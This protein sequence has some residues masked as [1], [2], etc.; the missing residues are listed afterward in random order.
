LSVKIL[1]QFSLIFAILI[2]SPVSFVLS[3]EKRIVINE[4]AWMGT[5]EQWQNE[6]IE[7]YN[8]TNSLIS[9]D[10]WIL[11]AKDD[12]PKI[13]LSGKIGAYSYFLLERTDDTTVPE[14]PADQVYKGGLNNQGE[15]L[16]LLNNFG[17]MVDE[18]DC[19]LG[20]FS[21]SNETKKTMERIHPLI[22]GCD[23]SNWKTS[24]KAG[25]TPGEENSPE[26]KIKKERDVETVSAASD[27]S[28]FSF[29]LTIGI[30]VSLFISMLV[31]AFWLKIKQKKDKIKTH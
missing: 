1:I 14:I 31:L 10:K 11:K 7:L 15:H 26:T 8:P 24:Q 4:I 23:P 17:E 12:S 9:L 18:T 29:L 3:Q 2:I 27:N 13:E 20:W 25:G 21:G 28:N 16:V 6:W 19:L 22:D 30:I 5:Q